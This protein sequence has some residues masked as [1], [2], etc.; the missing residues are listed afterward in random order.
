MAHL[1][2]CDFVYVQLS[3]TSVTFLLW[4][5][6]VRVWVY[7]NLSV[8]AVSLFVWGCGIHLRVYVQLSLTSVCV[9]HIVDC[10]CEIV[11]INLSLK[12]VSFFYVKLWPTYANLLCKIFAHIC[13]FAWNLL[14]RLWIYS[15]KISSYIFEFVLVKFPL[16][17]VSLFV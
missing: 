9:R 3:R 8:T 6:G 14:L 4:N 7:A 12:S 2:V 11:C 17:S 16:T 15:Y 1:K 10:I 5:C 13:G